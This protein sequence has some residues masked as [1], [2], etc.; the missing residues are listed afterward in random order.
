M[1]WA[2]VGATG[3]AREIADATLEH[4]VCHLEDQ[5]EDRNQRED[6]AEHEQ[7]LPKPKNSVPMAN[8]AV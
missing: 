2:A 6:I 3:R 5:Q 7:R 4:R 8:N 1:D